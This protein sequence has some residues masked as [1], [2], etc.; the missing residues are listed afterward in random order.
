MK[1]NRDVRDH[2]KRPQWLFISITALKVWFRSY[3]VA[4]VFE[5]FHKKIDKKGFAFNAVPFDFSFAW[6]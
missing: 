1:N 2:S 6:L 5:V 4:H 3:N